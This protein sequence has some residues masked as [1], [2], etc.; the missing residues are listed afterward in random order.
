MPNYTVTAG[1]IVQW[2]TVSIANGENTEVVVDWSGD[3]LPLARDYRHS[4]FALDCGTVTVKSFSRDSLAL[5]ESTQGS[6]FLVPANRGIKK[7][8][9][10]RQGNA[11]WFDADCIYLG[12]ELTAS[13]N[14]VFRYEHRFRIVE[15]V[16]SDEAGTYS[17]HE[18]LIF[19]ETPNR[20]FP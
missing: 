18:G 13:V 6:T 17:H 2:G 14:D 20:Q 11:I 19:T 16:T 12:S 5:T 9:R 10:V 1:T 4:R 7:N 3:A 15:T 8:L